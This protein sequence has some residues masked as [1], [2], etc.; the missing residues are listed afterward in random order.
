MNNL[1]LALRIPIMTQKVLVEHDHGAL[2]QVTTLGH[3]AIVVLRMSIN[4]PFFMN[5]KGESIA[6]TFDSLMTQIPD[7]IKGKGFSK[8]TRPGYENIE[9]RL[10]SALGERIEGDTV[11]KAATILGVRLP[12]NRW[13]SGEL[14]RYISY[15][16]QARSNDKHEM[17]KIRVLANSIYHKE[18]ITLDFQE[19]VEE[20]MPIYEHYVPLKP[21]Q[22]YEGYFATPSEDTYSFKR[23]N[24][25]TITCSPL[26]LVEG[27]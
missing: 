16:Q 27:S 14:N 7:E 8:E 21:G 26:G 24:T 20:E 3:K 18:G 23:S 12:R 17:Y 10:Y 13:E 4:Q 25:H 6:E 9:K 22:V 15:V 2:K 19:E 11:T 1:G 5:H